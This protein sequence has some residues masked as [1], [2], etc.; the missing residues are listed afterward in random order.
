MRAATGPG[1]CAGRGSHERAGRVPWPPV[2]TQGATTLTFPVAG[3]SC[4]AC[5][6]SIEHALGAVPGVL[7]ADVSYAAGS[8]RVELEAEFDRPQALRDAVHAAGFRTPE[9][10][11]EGGGGGI[12]EGNFD[13]LVHLY[14]HLQSALRER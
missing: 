8:A 3:M 5:A 1:A 6:Q 2:S 10:L 12:H 11:G 13:R 14:P 9:G 4:Q 7:D